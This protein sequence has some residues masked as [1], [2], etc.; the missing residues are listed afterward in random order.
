MPSPLAEWAGVHA[1]GGYFKKWNA[2]YAK[3]NSVQL[4]LP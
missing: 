3:A 2:M 4:N 1:F